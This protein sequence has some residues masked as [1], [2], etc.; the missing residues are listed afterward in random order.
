MV[1]SKVKFLQFRPQFAGYGLSDLDDFRFVRKTVRF[2]FWLRL[3]LN[4]R[5]GFFSPWEGVVDGLLVDVTRWHVLDFRYVI[6][7]SRSLG[8]W[9]GGYFEVLECVV[10]SHVFKVLSAISHNHTVDNDIFIRI[11][12]QF[13]FTNE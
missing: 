4:V 8:R 10:I 9:S 11:Q 1:E 13:S 12:S 6:A 5:H 7:R 2:R 3:R